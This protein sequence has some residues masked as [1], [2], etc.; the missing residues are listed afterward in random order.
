MKIGCAARCL[1]TARRMISG[2]VLKYRKGLFFIYGDYERGL[3]GSSG[4]SLTEPAQVS[5]PDCASKR[6]AIIS[7]SSCFCTLPLSVRGRFSPS[8]SV[9]NSLGIL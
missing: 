2:E 6:Q 9:M 1:I 4:F 5:A 7:S 8:R 3:C